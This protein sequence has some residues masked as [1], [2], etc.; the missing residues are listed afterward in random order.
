MTMKMK[1]PTDSAN[2]ME[3]LGD[4]TSS[5]AVTEMSSPVNGRT[6]TFTFCFEN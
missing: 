3:L 4:E 1:V 5:P 6:A 2:V